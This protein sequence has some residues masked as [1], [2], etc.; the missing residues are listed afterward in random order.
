MQYPPKL[1]R[2]FS[3]NAPLFAPAKT[4]SS[5]PS[6]SPFSLSPLCSSAAAAFDALDR[7]GSSG[8][9]ALQRIE[10]V[11]LDEEA[12]AAFADSAHQRWER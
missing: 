6:L 3:F 7:M 8:E 1:I 5:L 4:C 11:L 12:F 10:F 2:P 9:A